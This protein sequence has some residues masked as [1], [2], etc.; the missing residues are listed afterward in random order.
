MAP[1]DPLS[2]IK[3]PEALKRL[4]AKSRGGKRK[5]VFT[6]GV[7]D[8]LHR[9]HVTYLNQARKL[10]T[11]LVVALNEDEAVQRLK[12]PTRPLNRIADRMI[13]MAGLEC[14]DYVTC[15]GEDT[16]LEIIRMLK[17]NVLVKGGDYSP[18]APLGSPKYIVGAD[19][20]MSWGGSV[21]ALPFV[22]GYSTS[23]TIERF[24]K[25]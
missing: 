12:G 1:R 4:F 6:N 3:K 25:A 22:E 11:L 5:I 7:F 14:V 15:F 23:K 18:A 24:R 13:T 10:G 19:D 8:L 16:P 17:P 20:V 9:G 2:K 21:K